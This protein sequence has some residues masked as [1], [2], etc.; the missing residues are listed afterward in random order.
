M[1]F[2]VFGQQRE[3][4]RQVFYVVHHK[5]DA[6]VEFVEPARF[7]QGGMAGLFGQET[8]QLL[9]DDAEQIEILPIQLARERGAAEHDQ[10]DQPFEMEQR[11]ED[12]D[13]LFRDHPRGHQRHLARMV[14][15]FAH[16]VEI[17]DE[18]G[19]FQESERA[20]VDRAVGQFQR[21]P[22]PLRGQHQ[23]A[24]PPGF[25][26][27]WHQQCAARAVGDIGHRLD[28]ARVQRLTI[29]FHPADRLRKAQPFG[30]IVIAM[31]KEML[32]QHDV[33]RASQPR[34]R[35]QRDDHHGGDEGKDQLDQFR[36]IAARPRN[37]LRRG[38]HHDHVDAD[39]QQHERLKCN[40]A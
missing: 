15:A 8:G 31:L 26:W 2:G 29:G 16:L 7:E 13:R 14:G 36:R 6:A 39:D 25:R 17:D 34:R 4:A 24:P 32:G 38:D 18:A 21:R 5:R 27:P 30:A 37:R 19:A 1:A 35:H 40:S 3:L 12:P 20:R 9:P 33:D 10:P 22:S 11:D 28:H 23:R